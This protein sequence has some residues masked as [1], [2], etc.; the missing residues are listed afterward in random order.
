[1]RWF[2]NLKVRTKLVIGISVVILCMGV[3]ALTGYRNIR[4]IKTT[5][6]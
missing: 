2:R 5:K 1:M 6:Y 4:N 3:I